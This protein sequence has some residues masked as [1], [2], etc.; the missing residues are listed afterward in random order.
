MTD[1]HAS[2]SDAA[3]GFRK[4]EDI[5]RLEDRIGKH[6]KETAVK[7]VGIEEKL[8]QLIEDVAAMKKDVAE[9]ALLRV[10]LKWM[11][12]IGGAIIVFLVMPYLQGVIQ[13]N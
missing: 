4:H 5:A 7:F 13:I 9:I 6:E 11:K 12:I 1:I 2:A 8:D 10:D 3:G